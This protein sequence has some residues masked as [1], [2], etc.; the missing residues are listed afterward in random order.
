MWSCFNH[1]TD[2]FEGKRQG[3]IYCGAVSIIKLIYSR[4]KDRE[5]Y[6]VSCFNHKTDLFGGKDREVY[7]VELFQS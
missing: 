7:I 1:K 3:G 2:L 4:G 5:V 6:I